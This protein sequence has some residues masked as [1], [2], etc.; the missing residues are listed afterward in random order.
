MPNAIVL[1][2]GMIGSVMA[3]DLARDDEFTVT[4]ADRSEDVADRL[5]IYTIK[6]SF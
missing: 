5:A 2:A 6:R 1:G 3:W 4:I